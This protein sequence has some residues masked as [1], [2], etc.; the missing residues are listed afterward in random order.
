M[1][2]SSSP[3]DYDQ[4]SLEFKNILGEV[5]ERKLEESGAT[6]QGTGLKQPAFPG[7]VVVKGPL[8]IQQYYDLSG[9]IILR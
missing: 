9:M 3:N 7:S 5:F 1:Y 6:E 4:V 8:T 2:F